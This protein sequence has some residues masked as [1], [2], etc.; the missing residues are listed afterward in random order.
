MTVNKRWFVQVL[1]CLL[2]A[3]CV[4]CQE[5][6]GES[7]PA[8]TP[9]PGL[10]DAV[11][12]ITRPAEK[13]ARGYDL[14]PEGFDRARAHADYFKRLEVDSRPLQLSWLFAAADSRSS[15]R[16][17]LT[18]EPLSA[19][20]SLPLDTRFKARQPERLAEQLKATPHGKAILIC[21]HHGQ[22]PE[23]IHALGGD[24]DKLLPRG[25]W[26]GDVFNWVVELRYDAAGRV[27]S[28]QS[29]RIDENLMHGDAANRASRQ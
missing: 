23:L 26:P 8:S 24:P 6:P 14:S 25:K 12:L 28:G 27:I 7:G 15:H 29:K 22:I 13:P 9:A 18:L 11:M 4:V 1:F 3:D 17:R 19:A 16:P 21:R 5:Q 10:R 2:A 20:L